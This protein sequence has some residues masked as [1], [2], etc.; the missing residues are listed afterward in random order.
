MPLDDSETFDKKKALPSHYWLRGWKERIMKYD[1][2]PD[3]F[4]YDRITNWRDMMSDLAQLG[5]FDIVSAFEHSTK[6]ATPALAPS[7]PKRKSTVL[8]EHRKKHGHGHGHR[9][10]HGQGRSNGYG[11]G[12][13]SQDRHSDSDPPEWDKMLRTYVPY[14]PLRDPLTEDRLQGPF[15]QYQYSEQRLR[16]AADFE[17]EVSPMTVWRFLVLQENGFFGIIDTALDDVVP[18]LSETHGNCALTK[19]RIYRAMLSDSKLDGDLKE[20]ESIFNCMLEYGGLTFSSS[21]F[22]PFRERER[23]NIN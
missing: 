10:R 11:Y 21:F 23:E 18:R 20:G 14:D 5:C 17:F 13:G 1:N 12:H 3:V 9:H 22:F 16:T 19:C 7:P 2:W 15:Y 6:L 8:A 4:V